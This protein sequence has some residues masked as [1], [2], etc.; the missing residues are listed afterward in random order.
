MPLDDLPGAHLPQRASDAPGDIR[1]KPSVARV[2]AFAL[3]DHLS[4]ASA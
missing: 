4:E 2:F 1:Y 3:A